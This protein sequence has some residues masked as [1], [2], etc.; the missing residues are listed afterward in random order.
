ME[1]EYEHA[2]RIWRNDVGK[3]LKVIGGAPSSSG[4]AMLTFVNI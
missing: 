4:E 2:V 3:H 1:L